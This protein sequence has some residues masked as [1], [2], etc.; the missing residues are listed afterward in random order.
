MDKYDLATP[1]DS[2][3]A[4]Y[5]HLCALAPPTRRCRRYYG[6]HEARL[7]IETRSRNNGRST[8]H[9]WKTACRTFIAEGKAFRFMIP[10][11]LS[12]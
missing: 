7:G 6:D 11:V 5:K 8:I 3:T 9:S 4:F 10:T 1:R 12:F 2:K